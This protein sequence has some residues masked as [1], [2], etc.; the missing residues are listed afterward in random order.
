MID[1]ACLLNAC[2][3]QS[4]VIIMKAGRLIEKTFH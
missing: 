3:A 2:I 1:A 4:E